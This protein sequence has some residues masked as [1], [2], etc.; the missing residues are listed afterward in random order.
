MKY[1]DIRLN[2]KKLFRGVLSVLLCFSVISFAACSGGEDT[3]GEGQAGVGDYGFT[4]CSAADF[5][6]VREDWYGVPGVSLLS[7]R[8]DKICTSNVVVGEEYY[9]VYTT[10]WAESC[11]AAF[12]QVSCS[13]SLRGES[14]VFGTEDSVSL[15]E[16]MFDEKGNVEWTAE[17]KLSAKYTFENVPPHSY[18]I[19]PFIPLGA[20]QLVVET[21]AQDPVFLNV[22]S[23][24]HAEDG[25]FA[26]VSDLSVAW[27]DPTTSSP[28][29]DV[30]VG[31]G[32]YDVYAGKRYYLD[33]EFSL[34]AFG[35]DSAG[36]AV[37]CSVF[38]SGDFA[39][40][41]RIHEADTADYEWT[42]YAGKDVLQLRF[43]VPTQAEQ[44][45]TRRVTLDLQFASAGS[46]NEFS[47][48]FYSGEGQILGNLAETFSVSVYKDQGESEQSAT[49]GT[50]VYRFERETQSYIVTGI[51]EGV[52][53]EV[54][55]PETFRDYP[56]TEIAP[57]AFSDSYI[58]SITFSSMVRT[59]G[60]GAFSGCEDL[61]QVTFGMNVQTIGASAFSGC[62]SL[63]Q[64]ELPP[65]L[66]SVGEYAFASTPLQRVH[67]PEFVEEIG[68]GA[69]FC[70]TYIRS[71]YQAYRYTLQ[72]FTVSSRNEHF[73][74]VD[75]VLFTKDMYTLISF[76]MGDRMD[77]KTYTVPEGVREIAAAAFL[78]EEYT[79]S[80]YDPMTLKTVVLPASLERI[81]A[82]A[83][84]VNVFTTYVQNEGSDN[85]TG[86]RYNFRQ[87]D[88]VTF[89][90][91]GSWKCGNT[92]RTADEL[93]DAAAAAKFLSESEGDWIRLQ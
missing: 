48:T 27:L 3:D 51:Q 40:G 12:G 69:F 54:T 72:E 59:I 71:S 86:Y 89:T 43:E 74:S 30:Y 82:N 17:G 26:E 11:G 52:I 61:E 67:I 56:V 80:N 79:T 31:K 22:V 6:Q 37:I 46:K 88:S 64:V 76:P 87:Y 65:R 35:K 68:M 75:G 20:G 21:S 33:I 91:G 36:K 19:F 78:N 13:F 70:S 39:D 90:D 24:E 73:T 57:S 44:K 85:F 42:E 62:D 16:I 49:D 66:V 93:S 34:Q 4:V 1:N 7:E 84:Y 63:E 50:L 9:L 23:A 25:A 10:N 29:S 18:L 58:Q 55:I 77:R 53:K 14:G 47:I 8:A 92:V 38:C 15:G 28:V 60:A 5:A 81:A 45:Q 32:Y 2:L 83:F 41:I